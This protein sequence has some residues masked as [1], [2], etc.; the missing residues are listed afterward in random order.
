VG[1]QVEIY[2]LNEDF[3]EFFR[4]VGSE[5]VVVLPKRSAEDPLLQAK[6]S[7]EAP[8]AGESPWV[9]L[10]IRAMLKN[11]KTQKA[12]GVFIVSPNESP[13]LELDRPK[14]VGSALRMGRLY[15]GKPS[16]ED[17]DPIEVAKYHRWLDKCLAWPKRHYHRLDGGEYVSERVEA[18][19]KEGGKLSRV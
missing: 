12:A 19:M 9:E 15:D 1:R 17:Y 6:S 8:R 3:D 4:A 11:V 5:D 7:L 13:V 10:T 16:L 14:L 18:F 2:M